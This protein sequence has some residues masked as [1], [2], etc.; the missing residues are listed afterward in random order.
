MATYVMLTHL[1]DE[2]MRNVKESPARIEAFKKSARGFGAEVREVYLAI[3]AYDTVCLIS[4]PD[5]ET[6]CKVAL[7]LGSL[8]NVRTETMRLFSESE[9]KKLA[10]AIP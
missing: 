9:F 6:M 3:G 8:G 10:G 7:A 4:A 2:G 5:D 1:T